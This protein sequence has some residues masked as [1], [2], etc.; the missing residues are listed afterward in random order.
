MV[1]R[2]FRLCVIPGT[3]QLFSPAGPAK[4][5]RPVPGAYFSPLSPF[6][7]FLS[8]KWVSSSAAALQSKSTEHFLTY[9][10]T[11][12]CLRIARVLHI[13]KGRPGAD[14]GSGNSESSGPLGTFQCCLRSQ[15]KCSGK[16]AA[17]R[18]GTSH[19]V[20]YVR[21]VP[22]SPMQSPTFW[23]EEL[24]HLRPRLR[25]L[26]PDFP[27]MGPASLCLGMALPSGIV[28]SLSAFL[29]HT[30]TA[31]GPL[32][33]KALC[34]LLPRIPSFHSVNA[35]ALWLPTPIKIN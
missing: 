4:P 34:W 8:R 35:N 15:P 25:H 10:G 33:L 22:H 9:D 29:S 23:S 27:S 1:P 7:S 16:T 5:H 17:A 3:P 2:E 21:C 31:T 19:Y 14:R 20:S 28:G 6:Y 32:Q 24:W 12:T 11:S 13:I 30:L 26:W 18:S